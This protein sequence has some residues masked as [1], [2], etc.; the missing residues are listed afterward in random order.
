[1]SVVQV[2]RRQHVWSGLRR[3]SGNQATSLFSPKLVL[4]SCTTLV[5]HVRALR[6]IDVQL[7]R[8]A[9]VLAPRIAAMTTELRL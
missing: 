6:F 9:I 2:D 5:E 8:N 4:Y 3:W 7:V 1:M